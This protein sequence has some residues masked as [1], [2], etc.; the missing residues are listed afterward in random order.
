MDSQQLDLAGVCIC[1]SCF[2]LGFVAAFLVSLLFH[3]P[4]PFIHLLRFH[5]FFEYVSTV[6]SYTETDAFYRLLN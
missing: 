5:S 6:A 1:P 2:E 4:L 3:C